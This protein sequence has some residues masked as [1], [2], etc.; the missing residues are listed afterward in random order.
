L[1]YQQLL[2]YEFNGKPDNLNFLF[3]EIFTQYPN[4]LD[5]F[6]DKLPEL[7]AKQQEGK[8]LPNEIKIDVLN[9]TSKLKNLA[10]L[11]TSDLLVHI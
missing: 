8:R 9:Q 11:E 3:N 4:F 1:S 10:Q 7:G 5:S 2:R 6:E